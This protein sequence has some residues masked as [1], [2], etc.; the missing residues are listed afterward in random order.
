MT[1]RKYLLEF[2]NF[3]CRFGNEKVLLDLAEEIVI[4]AFTDSEL[5]RS[6]G[7]TKYFFHQVEILEL[8]TDGDVSI[9]IAGR[10]V[11][12][13]LI[14]REQIFDEDNERL[15]RD[16]QQLQTSPSSI[17]IL[18][19]NNHKLLYVHETLYAPSIKSFESTIKTF[20]R[21]KHSEYI[22]RLY[23]QRQSEEVTYRS[24]LEEY[25]DSELEIVPLASEGSIGEFI[26]QFDIL[27]KVEINLLSTNSELD[28]S[29]FWDDARESGE[30]INSKKTKIEYRNDT[31]G[32]LKGAVSS[33]IVNTASN[34]KIKLKGKDPQG[35]IL[36][37]SNDSFKIKLFL[38]DL[39]KSINGIAK[40][41]YQMF[42]NLKKH[43]TPKIAEISQ[44]AARKVRSLSERLRQDND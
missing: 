28:F 24:L 17:F 4:P 27:Q 39:P 9:G 34:S 19:L 35:A 15:V 14:S 29:E 5:E 16:P 1:K 32:L 40:L 11:K 10:F 30:S 33:Q 18:I 22:N 12:D 13:T 23:E 6:Y 37:G 38:D 42:D 26:N 25:P 20:I 8:Q 3:V 43:G 31:E 36:T 44:D 7:S 41:S 2:A 21:M